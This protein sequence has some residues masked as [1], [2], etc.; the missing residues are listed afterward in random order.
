M[1]PFL[2]LGF[3]VCLA[4]YFDLSNMKSRNSWL[5]LIVCAV[6]AFVIVF[7]PAWIIQPFKYQSSEGIRYSYLLR[8]WSP[9]LTLL[10]SGCAVIS[11]FFLWRQA[12]RWWKRT[13]ILMLV[14]LS[15]VFAWA[16]RQNHFEW[17]FN[18]LPD[19]T[20]ASA[21]DADFIGPS[22]MVLAININN[23][24]V[25]YPVRQLAYHH[26]VNDIAGGTPVVSTY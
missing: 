9:I 7:I 20:Y 1:K 17:M 11:A 6:V 22:D 4:C 23:D 18:P 2:D 26:L 13:V 8:S 10:L 15:G 24:A 19:D 25:A 16:A 12:T 21:K 5:I 3:Q 14:L